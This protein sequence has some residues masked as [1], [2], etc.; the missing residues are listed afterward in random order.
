MKEQENI[1]DIQIEKKGQKLTRRPGRISPH[2]WLVLVRV[3]RSEII[4][5]INL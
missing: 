4:G 3:Q 1:L 5:I 2:C